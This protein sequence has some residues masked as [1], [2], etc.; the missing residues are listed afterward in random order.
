[1]PARLT[2]DG[3]PESFSD[4]DLKELLAP[5]GHVLTARMIQAQYFPTYRYGFVKM[6]TMAEAERA[7][8]VLNRTRID[9]HLILVF[10]ATDED[11][12]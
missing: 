3:L 10:I 5:Y 9:G 4:D 7:R 11:G 12:R 8:E 1:V 2:V 6:A